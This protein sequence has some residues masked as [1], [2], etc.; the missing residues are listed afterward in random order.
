MR[1]GI[2]AAMEVETRVLLDEMGRPEPTLHAQMPVYQG[3]ISQH[4]IILAQSGIGKVNAAMATTVLIETYQAELVINTGVA[5]GIGAGLQVGDLVI[6]TSCAYHDADN[7]IFDYEY[8]QIPQMP[9]RFLA[10]PDFT[11]K[12]EALARD[13]WQTRQ[14]LVVSGDSFVADSNQI[15]KIKSFFPDAEVTE[16]EGAAI[17]QVCHEYNVPFVIVRAVSDTA[18]EA[19]TVLYEEFVTE[20]GA[21][22]GQ[23]LI[24]YLE[25]L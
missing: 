6:S 15:A 7:R 19:A 24:D 9:A 25:S 22:S 14:G 21:K 11:E 4:E 23:L 13:G 8:G 3:K 5:G 10:D 2:I 1:I 17:A 18:D 16:M 12:F 20:T